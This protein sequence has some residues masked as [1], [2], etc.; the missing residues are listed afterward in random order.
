MVRLTR[1]DLIDDG[2]EDPQ[3]RLQLDENQLPD[4]VHVSAVHADDY[5]WLRIDHARLFQSCSEDNGP[6]GETQTCHDLQ[7]QLVRLQQRLCEAF[8]P[9]PR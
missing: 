7:L 3:W 2:T 4:Q 6:S 5:D 1:S 9:N 8:E